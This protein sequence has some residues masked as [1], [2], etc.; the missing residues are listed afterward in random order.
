[1]VDYNTVKVLNTFFPNIVS[2]LNT[3]EY[4]YNKHLAHNIT[5]PVLKCVL[6]YRK[7]PSILAIG[8]VCN[9]NPR[10]PFSFLKINREEILREIL[11][12]KTSKALQHFDILTKIIKENS[13]IFVDVLLASLN[14]SV[15]KR[16]N[17]IIRPP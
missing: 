4:S 5:H 3:A 8:E 17:L 9:K 7:H 15:E 14:D 12:L 16:K 6:K 10:L 2:N 1:M 13:D 11:K